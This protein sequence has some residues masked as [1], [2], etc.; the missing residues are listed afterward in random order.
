MP[1]NDPPIQEVLKSNNA[2]DEELDKASR[3]VSPD[4]V[5]LIHV[6]QLG[7][8]PEEAKKTAQQISSR[9][10]IVN[11]LIAAWNASRGIAAPGAAGGAGAG[12]GAIAQ[13]GIASPTATPPA[14]AVA[15][16]SGGAGGIIVNSGIEQITFRLPDWF[17][18]VGNDPNRD[19]FIGPIDL[20]WTDWLRVAISCNLTKAIRLTPR[21]REIPAKHAFRW[22][23]DGPAWSAVT[24]ADLPEGGRQVSLEYT[25]EDHTAF[26]QTM[27]DGSL[28]A[29]YL[30]VTAAGSAN[31][32]S[33]L[34]S[35]I[36][37]KK[38]YMGLRDCVPVVLVHLKDSLALSPEFEA[39]LKRIIDNPHPSTAFKDLLK[40]MDE[41]G[42]VVPKEVVLGG[43]YFFENFRNVK[44]WA[45]ENS[46]TLK[47]NFKL[48][49]AKQSE[50]HKDA[51]PPPAGAGGGLSVSWD[52][53]KK[54]W[55]QGESLQEKISSFAVGG[56]DR[57][58]GP[59]EWRMTVNHPDRWRVIEYRAA[60]KAKSRTGEDIWVYESIVDRL[61]DQVSKV[62]QL[63]ERGRSTAWNP[64]Q[65]KVSK[66]PDAVAFPTPLFWDPDKGVQLV[67]IVSMS[68][69][70]PPVLQAK[71]GA[72]TPAPTSSERVIP[73]EHQPHLLWEDREPIP[74]QRIQ[75]TPA[76]IPG[77]GR[78]AGAFWQQCDP[79]PLRLPR[80]MA[81]DAAENQALWRFEY[82]GDYSY[83]GDPLYW[84]VSA[85]GE[86]LLSGFNDHGNNV[87]WAN[88]VPAAGREQALAGLSP[89]AWVVYPADPSGL[90]PTYNQSYLIYNPVLNAV[91]GPEGSQIKGRQG[92][93][94]AEHDEKHFEDVNP[95]PIGGIQWHVAKF[96]P[97]SHRIARRDFSTGEVSMARTTLEK[98]G[99][100]NQQL[101]PAQIL[102]KLYGSKDL[103]AEY[104][105]QI[106]AAG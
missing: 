5:D 52:D 6:S 40:L 28:N 1:A 27:A 44:Q 63:W 104:A 18:P 62:K 32:K 70:A 36:K 34:A 98:F 64:S 105:W 88:L 4:G 57:L 26:R 47:L 49:V 29:S 100:G 54:D 80:N 72:T 101:R 60:N 83:D 24:Q 15:N 50:G 102:E 81:A 43:Y 77:A 85:S 31:W 91:L 7:K 53:E 86:W 96:E 82:T 11:A 74:Q 51:A 58:T 75:V 35:E 66:I 19:K 21:G 69:T 42:H 93:Y 48:A 78:T 61:P 38:L 2:T 65:K 41:Y 95:Y 17:T 97:V 79:A 103:I 10:V 46:D 12:A 68:T 73:E 84:I 94:E 76:E 56:N 23:V 25:S 99:A 89:A 45:A 71:N 67:T 59:N 87:Y 22:K 8:N 90:S 92:Y 55:M 20:K 39:A 106:K 14:G 13:G 37:S 9:D 30:F 3:A 33:N 16:L